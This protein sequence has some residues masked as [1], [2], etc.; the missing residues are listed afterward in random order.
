VAI[1]MVFLAWGRKAGE[2]DLG[3]QLLTVTERCGWQETIGL[4]FPI[5]RVSCGCRR[6]RKGDLGRASK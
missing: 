3:E 5:E 4:S 6:L 1:I 2:R